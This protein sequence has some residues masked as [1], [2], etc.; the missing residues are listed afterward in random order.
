MTWFAGIDPGAAGALALYDSD[1]KKIVSVVDM[2]IFMQTVGRTRKPRVDVPALCQIVSTWKSIGVQIVALENVGGIPKQSATHAFTFGFSCGVVYGTLIGHRLAVDMVKPQIWKKMLRCG[3]END[4]ILQRAREIFD[5][6]DVMWR[7]PKGGFR[8]G[9]AEA[10]MMA[11]Y[12]AKYSTG[13]TIDADIAG[14]SR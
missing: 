10:A 2:P 8:D 11:L 6:P 12:A 3:K 4:Q 7:G 13:G 5:V 1:S 9:R 14:T